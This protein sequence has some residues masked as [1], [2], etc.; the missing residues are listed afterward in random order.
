MFGKRIKES[1]LHPG[2]LG[3]LVFVLI[4]LEPCAA[5]L[6][7]YDILLPEERVERKYHTVENYYKFERTKVIEQ[8]HFNDQYVN[9]KISVTE[10]TPRHVNN[11]R[12]TFFQCVN[13][14][15]RNAKISMNVIQ[16]GL[17]T[18]ELVVRVIYTPVQFSVRS[19]LNI[20]CHIRTE[21]MYDGTVGEKLLLNLSG[22]QKTNT[23]P[24]AVVLGK[25]MKVAKEWN[26]CSCPTKPTSVDDLRSVTEASTR[27]TVKPNETSW[28]REKLVTSSS[29]DAT[30]LRAQKIK[31]ND[32]SSLGELNVDMQ[33]TNQTNFGSTKASLSISSTNNNN[34]KST[35]LPS[36]INLNSVTIEKPGKSIIQN[37]V[38]ISNQKMRTA[39][40]TGKL[41]TNIRKPVDSSI[42]SSHVKATSPHVHKKTS[43]TEVTNSLK[44]NMYGKTTSSTKKLKMHT[45]GMVVK[46]ITKD[47]KSG[48]LNDDI[49][50][51]RETGQ[52][53]GK[54]GSKLK[55][56]N[57]TPGSGIELKTNATKIYNK[58]TSRR[59]DEKSIHNEVT[60]PDQDLTTVPYEGI[61]TA[62]DETTHSGE[63][64]VINGMGERIKASTNTVTQPLTSTR[65]VEMSLEKS[66]TSPTIEEVTQRAEING[67]KLKYKILK[68]V[69]SPWYNL[70][71]KAV[72]KDL[73]RK[74]SL[75]KI[76]Y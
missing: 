15:P 17:G 59:P 50:S 7:R 6:M 20:T 4:A 48:N 53:P 33:G 22:V 27:Y 69:T 28:N 42:I 67:S 49:I 55:Y 9:L 54:L 39:N 23:L 5:I 19:M 36:T 76:T 3:V 16:G 72:P 52:R 24:A 30:S 64:C 62:I 51:S 45:T 40:T 14:T 61:V 47:P 63:T 31:S 73:K 60:T 37:E 1:I 41:S 66:H 32:K 18:P 68:G 11:G 10:E 12:I 58:V 29:I 21:N 8:D 34:R 56:N 70:A 2:T 38:H 75:A 74:I 35:S 43:R 44:T 65:T 46:T 57:K 26:S 13:Q 25:K 71:I